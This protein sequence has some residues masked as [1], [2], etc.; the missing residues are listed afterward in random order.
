MLVL[1]GLFL[2]LALFLLGV[3]IAVAVGFLTLLCFFLGDVPLAIVPQ[4]LYEASANYGLMACPLFILAGKFME[5]GGISQRLVDFALAL[6]GRA[7]GGLGYA[8]MVACMFMGGISGSAIA[9][10]TAVGAITA[11]AMNSKNY[12]KGFTASMLAYGGA[13]GS[14]IPPSI[15]MIVLATTCSISVGKLFLA[16][17]LPGLLAGLTAMSVTYFLARKYNFPRERKYSFREILKATWTA[18][19]TLAIPVFIVIAIIGG[20]LTITEVAAFTAVY[21]FLLGFFVYRELKLKDLP[22]LF[23][24]S[25][26]ATSSVLI[27]LAFCAAFA[28]LI[29][30]VQLPDAIGAA[31]LEFT[32]NKVLILVLMVVVLT[33][34]GTII[35]I[36]PNIMITAPIILPIMAGLGVDT[37]Y[38]ALLMV[39]VLSMGLVTPPVGTTLFVACAVTGIPQHDTYKY[40]LLLVGGA[41]GL[42]AL[43]LLFPQIVMFLPNYLME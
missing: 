34:M 27:V 30:Y 28:W 16:G 20:I 29:M 26:E 14:I 10:T 6:V 9:D 5:S 12:P 19:P 4:C 1:L 31:L 41:T 37:T 33:L 42:V 38:V 21:S 23:V 15:P 25:V 8:S 2:L 36:I 11:P 35:D 7:R 24:E 22:R 18:L 40:V 13:L 43:F 3:P 32:Q 17:A 39:F